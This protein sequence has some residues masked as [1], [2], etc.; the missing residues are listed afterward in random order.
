MTPFSQGSADIWAVKVDGSRPGPV[1]RQIQVKRVTNP[2]PSWANDGVRYLLKKRVAEGVSRE[3]WLHIGDS[4]SI[5]C[6]VVIDHTG[7]IVVEGREPWATKTTEGLR[8]VG[9]MR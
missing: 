8:R 2:E 5:V 1:A 7:T 6:R 9:L 4:R 3:C